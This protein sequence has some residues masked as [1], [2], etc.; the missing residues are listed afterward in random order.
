MSVMSLDWRTKTDLP[1][2]WF[3]AA[4][5]GQPSFAATGL[6]FA[7]ADC[8]VLHNRNLVDTLDTLGTTTVA[9]SVGTTASSSV[10]GIGVVP[11]ATGYPQNVYCPWLIAVCNGDALML[12][13]GIKITS[14]PGD[15]T[16][17]GGAIAYSGLAAGST[18]TIV[19]WWADGGDGNGTI[20]SI[21]KYG[22]SWLGTLLTPVGTTSYLPVTTARPYIG[23][24]GRVMGGEVFLST[25][26]AV[27]QTTLSGAAPVSPPTLFYSGYYN[28]GDTLG[29]YNLS[30]M[31]ISLSP[32]QHSMYF[33]GYKEAVFSPEVRVVLKN[34]GGAWGNFTGYASSGSAYQPPGL[35]YVRHTEIQAAAVDIFV[36]FADYNTLEYDALA[37]TVSVKLQSVF[38]RM[39]DRQAVP[40]TDVGAGMA[41][42]RV[43]L[44]SPGAFGEVSTVTGAYGEL[45]TVTVQGDFVTAV[46]AGDLI[47]ESAGAETVLVKELISA[48]SGECVFT[49]ANRPGWLKGGAVLRA[50]RPRL[51]QL[52][53][54]WEFYVAA[55]S[56]PLG[57]VDAEA[58]GGAPA[59]S[60][61]LSSE[62]SGPL[63]DIG[64]S[65]AYKFSGNETFLEL[66]K[67]LLSA[68][69]G[70]MGYDGQTV[71][72]F[73]PSL[74]QI[75][76][77]S[78]GTYSFETVAYGDSFK[79]G[80]EQ[81][82][83][84]IVMNYGWDTDEKD[85]AMSL[86]IESPAGTPGKELTLS[87]RLVRLSQQAMETAAALL[88]FWG[89]GAT[90]N[91]MT[92]ADYWTDF[93]PGLIIDMT[94]LPST[95][96]ISQGKFLVIGRVFDPATLWVSVSLLE[97]PLA[98]G[99]FFRVGIDA[100]GGSTPVL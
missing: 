66:T 80:V 88:V 58:Y 60:W 5:S 51:A 68:S 67:E 49:V 8:L 44:Y 34:E 20:T 100:I 99:D 93:A 23:H 9:F 86:D 10:N 83:S 30:S 4:G 94:D 18:G 24:M 79:Q 87:T 89:G 3:K 2:G 61:S 76:G 52:N 39:L 85:Y 92:D 37:Q 11:Y 78:A 50:N 72:F 57:K 45:G 73:T 32:I 40:A 98:V 48:E 41:A 56:E 16:Y 59:P 28:N 46:E 17:Q 19:S 55:I 69:G 42:S 64:I 15:A 36:G 31:V 35:F 7:G 12:S 96:H 13:L 1:Y 26:S 91:F 75:T 47:A 74:P 63:L 33:P 84:R 54:L 82:V 97:V 77:A 6:Q 43:S 25:G 81:P 22:A 71:S 21:L 14:D 29:N 65:P 27:Y 53:M 90:V 38:G 62:S 95:Y 70:G